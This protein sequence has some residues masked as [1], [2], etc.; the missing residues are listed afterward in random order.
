MR[1]RE[2]LVEKDMVVGWFGGR[3]REVE[4]VYLAA[5]MFGWVPSD[6]VPFGGDSFLE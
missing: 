6:D 5:G 1:R 4:P 3:R 2:D